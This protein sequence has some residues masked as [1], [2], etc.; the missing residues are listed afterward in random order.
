LMPRVDG[1]DGDAVLGWLAKVCRLEPR[2]RAR[3]LRAGFIAYS[4]MGPVLALEKR[5]FDEWSLLPAPDH[6]SRY[7]VRKTARLV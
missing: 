4:H 6:A 3:V 2:R 5:H 7:R 1:G